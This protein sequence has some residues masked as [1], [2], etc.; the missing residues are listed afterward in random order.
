MRKMSLLDYLLMSIVCLFF[1]DNSNSEISL[2]SIKEQKINRKR[3]K[4]GFF[5]FVGGNK[6][7]LKSIVFASREFFLELFILIK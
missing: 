1:T 3:V 7:K 6:A 5:W 2:I 4:N